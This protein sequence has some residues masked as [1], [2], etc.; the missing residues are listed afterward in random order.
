M[1][2][3]QVPHLSIGLALLLSAPAAALDPSP[4]GGG[5]TRLTLPAGG[6]LLAAEVRDGEAGDGILTVVIEGDGPGA[7]SGPFVSGAQA[8]VL[9]VAYLAC[10][11]AL[12]AV[13]LRRRDVA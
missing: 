9:L 3:R 5:W 1:R 4:G 6:R 12:S 10:F 8:F 13:V 2:R 7:F 11:V